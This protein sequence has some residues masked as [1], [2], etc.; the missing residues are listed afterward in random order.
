MDAGTDANDVLMG[1]VIPLR[2]G[3]VGVVNRSQQDINNKKDI[4]KS[5]EDEH[6]FFS[7]HP[8]YRSIASKSESAFHD[9]LSFFL[10]L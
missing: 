10:S 5:V 1:R 7:N 6:T 9:F 4:R 8:A 2:L 3:Y